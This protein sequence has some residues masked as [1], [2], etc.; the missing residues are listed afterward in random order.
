MLSE[1]GNTELDDAGL[2]G[3]ARGGLEGPLAVSGCL[4]PPSGR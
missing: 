2:T 1:C 4:L 3:G